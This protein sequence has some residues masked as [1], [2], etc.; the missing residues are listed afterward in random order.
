[1]EGPA[2]EYILWVPE[3]NMARSGLCRGLA[4]GQQIG[5]G[6]RS[7]IR[8]DGNVWESSGEGGGVLS[9]G[10]GREDE[11]LSVRNQ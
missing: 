5:V 1:M 6:A 2:S 7:K 4:T 9:W 3:S 11:V 10:S 8:R